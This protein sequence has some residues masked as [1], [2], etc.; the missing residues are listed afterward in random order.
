MRR[1]KLFK[2]VEAELASLESEINDWLESTGFEVVSISG[3]IAPQTH[4]S[5]SPESFST[6]DILLV[7][8][9]EAQHG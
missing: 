6:S 5:D 9:Y 4:F 3:N 2:G 7:V 1:V 8:T